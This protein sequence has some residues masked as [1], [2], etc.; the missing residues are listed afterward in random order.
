MAALEAE[1]LETEVARARAGE[2]A[3]RS[4][5]QEAKRRRLDERRALVEAKRAQLLG[6]RERLAQ[7]RAQRQQGETEKFFAELDEDIRRSESP[8]KRPVPLP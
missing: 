3:G 5:A 2:R 8:V 6:G 7:L 1:R 4:V